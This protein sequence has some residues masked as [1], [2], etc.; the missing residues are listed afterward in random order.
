MIYPFVEDIINHTPKRK[1]GVFKNK[2]KQLNL[3][4]EDAVLHSKSK[5]LILSESSKAWNTSILV[6]VVL[7]FIFIFLVRLFS[8]QVTGGGTNLELSEKNSVREFKLQAERGVIYD[9]NGEVL[10]RNRPAFGITLNSD[11][12]IQDKELKATGNCSKDLELITKYIEFNKE[13]VL[14]EL[15]QGKKII[16]IKN[17]VSKKDILPIEANLSS[18]PSVSIE[19]APQ[20]DYLY[21][22]AFAHAIGYVG[23]GNTIYPSIAGKT[24]VELQYNSDLQ[25]FDGSRVVQV[26]SMGEAF[27]VLAETKPFPGKDITLNI[28]KDLQIKAYELIKKAVEE[29]DADAGVVVA[30]D[31]RDGGVL[32]L[33]NYPSFNPDQMSTGITQQEYDNVQESSY[34][35]F[36]NRAISGTY[37]PG[38]TFKMVVAAAVLMEKI[39]TADTT[40]N[41]PGYISVSGF[42]FRN[43]KL[44]G[45]GVVNLKRALQVSNDVYFYTVGGGFGDIK[46]L[47]I[48]K[49]ALWAKKFGYGIKTGIDLPGEVAGYMPD[50][51]QRQWYLGDTFISSI[52]QGDILSTPLQVNNMTTYFANGGYL[53]VPSVVKSINGKTDKE[54]E[55]IS[56]SLT[57]SD[58]YNLIREGMHA[59]TKFGGT[60][61]TFFD[62]PIAH[63]GVEVAGKTGTS[64]Y[65]DTKGEER[66]HAWFTVF[67]PYEEATIA[68]T[69]FLEGGGGGSTDAGPIA[70]ELMDVWFSK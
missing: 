43:W 46:G 63:E 16:L 28:D 41:D 64:E 70:R 27:E 34:F 49:L 62:F 21:K 58:S 8:L 59:V 51:T 50:G 36:F 26:N 31:P 14:K 67:G 17:N 10:V 60:G 3:I 35:P 2:I 4:G 42:T 55:V 13:S 53:F 37:P 44:D 69:V 11:F 29:G 66:T 19:V 32:A 18:I 25:G 45:H 15:S 54:L 48:E 57:D 12:C 40:V 22:D 6:I 5:E 23:L 65:F 52:G 1:K 20:R 47:G 68:L 30:Q 9:R 61:Y 39:V 7:I 56:Q 38:S 33:V 24:G